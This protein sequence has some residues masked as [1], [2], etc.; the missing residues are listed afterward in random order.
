MQSSKELIKLEQKIWSEGK[1]KICHLLKKEHVFLDVKTND[2][3]ELL[4]EFVLALK[5]TKAIKDDNV[6][7]EALLKR[8]GLGSTGLEKGFAVP[9]ALVDGIEEP[10][11]ALSVIRDGID[12]NAADSKPSYVV[13]LLLGSKKNPGSQ[14]KILAHLCRLV[15][16]TNFVEAAKKSKS[17]DEVY[18]ILG[19]DEN[20]IE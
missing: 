11:I 7:L 14:L 4:K 6:I 19:C 10:I 2:K 13:M 15:K 20:A 18:N 9:H 12:F 8:E 3:N 5:E 16:E 17:P 1:M